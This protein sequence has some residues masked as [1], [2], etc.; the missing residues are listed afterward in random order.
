MGL[1]LVKSVDVK[2]G[3]QRYTNLMPVV[4]AGSDPCVMGRDYRTMRL[5]W[6]KFGKVSMVPAPADLENQLAALQDK[7]QEVFNNMLGTITQLQA[8]LTVSPNAQPKFFKPRP[9]PLH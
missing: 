5:D 7:Y 3:Q 9:V 8:K 1:A 2:Y 4:V 6:G